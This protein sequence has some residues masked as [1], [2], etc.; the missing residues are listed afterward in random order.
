MIGSRLGPYE[1]TAK[2]GEGG[3]GEVYR[4][5]D[6]RLK[7]E[8]AVKVLPAAFTE[9]RERLARFEREAQLLAQLHHPNIASIFGLEESD[10]TRALVMELVEG[11]TLAER[12]ASGALPLPESL[13]IARQIAEAL[14]E[15]HEKG[16][17]HRD[18]KPA[19]V[20]VTDEGKVKVLDF[21]L[22]KALDPMAASGSGAALASPAMLSSPTLTAAHGTALGMILGTAAYMSPEQ[23][24]GKAVDKRADVWS[25]GAVFFEMLAG[26]RLFAGETV[27]DTLAA[28][29]RADPDWSA[30]PP[31]LPAPLG[32]LLRR[33]L[34]RDPRRRL[35]DVADAR[36][37][38][39][40]VLEGRWQP[41]PSAPPPAAL[42]PSLARR[43]AV[44]LGALLLGSLVTAAVLWS[45]RHDAGAS[46][47]RQPTGFRQL[48]FLAGAEMAPALSPDGESLA[49][50]KEIDGQK[51]VFL[52]RVGG[53]NPVNL[54]AGCGEDDDEPAFSPD[55]RRI[56][57]RSECAGGG[58]F[59]MGATGESTRKV[60]AEGYNP[61]WSPDGLELAVADEKLGSPFGRGTTSHI[62]VVHVETGERRLL[63]ERDGMQPAFS[64]DGRRVAFWGLDEVSAR[65]DLFTV[66]AD[67]SQAAPEAAVRLL[68][69]PPVDWSPIWSGDGRSILFSSTRGG[70]MNLWRI[71]VDPASGRPDGAP[72][73]VTVPS[74]WAGPLSA[75]ADGRRFAFVDR[76]VRSAIRV[77]PFDP[78]AATFRGVPR[79]VPLGTLEVHDTISLS[80]D[81]RTVLF[82][83]AGLPQHLFLHAESGGLRQLTEGEHRDRQGF[84]SPDGTWIVFQTDRWPGRLG[85]VRPDGS[86]LRELPTGRSTSAWYPIWSPD[87][88]LVAAG[89]TEGPVLLALADGAASGPAQP[90]A[91]LDEA[92]LAFWPYSFSPDSRRL[93]GTLHSSA[94]SAVGAAV[95]DIAGR[96]FRP[97]PVDRLRNLLLLADGRRLLVV[98]RQ[99]LAVVDPETGASRTIAAPADGWSIVWASFS[100]DGRSL[101]WHERTDE[102]DIWLAEFEERE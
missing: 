83:Q 53:S 2:L 88:R 67:G 34:E 71:G 68:G 69:D 15:A 63:S 49:Y 61:S 35:H 23:A 64:P 10:G 45:A 78:A 51:D 12:L 52:Q 74:S 95:Y 102:S 79:E 47:E 70:T 99:G 80:P 6:T 22:A 81:G 62:R 19:N 29:L 18:L 72:Q 30:L 57:Y 7:R 4:G 17:V 59:V 56:A 21:G 8:V 43:A 96:S 73:P 26:Q 39:E 24:R 38:I 48:T 44:P 89:G 20:K 14:E 36:I 75:S 54:T 32:E 41:P 86:G 40:E 58:I 1:I 9:D 65:R 97:L 46:A 82:D 55:G 42:H 90:L 101:A 93:V 77:V 98:G 25:F 3:M 28:V 11:P 100:G 85:L 50:V 87:G 27:S 16:I 37:V 84:F 92:G 60:T 5:T 76:N 33:C 31:G 94:N 13:S 66:A 91:P